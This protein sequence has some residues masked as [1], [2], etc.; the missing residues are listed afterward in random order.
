MN[1]RSFLEWFD[2]GQKE[3][4]FFSL[5]FC[6]EK[7][8]D[9]LSCR[10]EIGVKVKE[11]CDWR[12]LSILIPLGDENIPS[13]FVNNEKFQDILSD[14]NKELSRIDQES[15]SPF[16]RDLYLPLQITTRHLPYAGATTSTSIL[17]NRL[18]NFI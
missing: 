5:H 11:I 16:S 1:E 14:V 4:S 7:S 12:L 8:V 10:S 9:G 17:T 2:T 15:K 6:D 13:W 18:S 3:E